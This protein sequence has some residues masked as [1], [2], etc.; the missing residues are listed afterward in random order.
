MRV[1]N[2]NLDV[3]QGSRWQL[4][5]ES[6]GVFV[7]GGGQRE[8]FRRTASNSVIVVPQ[9]PSESL[10]VAHLFTFRVCHHHDGTKLSSLMR[11]A[12]AKRL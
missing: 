2:V 12:A 1:I 10:G 11:G 6:A 4:D 5:W 8:G 3:G 9:S 7:S